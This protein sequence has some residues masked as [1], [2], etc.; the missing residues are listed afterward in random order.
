MENAGA[1]SSSA[2]APSSSN[3]ASRNNSND[4]DEAGTPNDSVREQPGQPDGS[5][6]RGNAAAAARDESR[7][8]SNAGTRHVLIFLIDSISSV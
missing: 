8:E 3:D 6:V 2:G 5:E 7:Q 1:G 4:S